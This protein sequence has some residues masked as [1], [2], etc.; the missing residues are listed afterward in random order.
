MNSTKPASTTADSASISSATKTRNISGSLTYETADTVVEQLTM[1]TND[2]S[3]KTATSVVKAT[4]IT[5]H[6]VQQMIPNTGDEDYITAVSTDKQLKVRISK[7]DLDLIPSRDLL[8]LR[9]NPVE[10]LMNM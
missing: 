2:S 1:S 9:T 10:F 5:A 7:H 4:S 8:A 6:A 3:L